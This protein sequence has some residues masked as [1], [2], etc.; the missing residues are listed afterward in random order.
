M[1]IQKFAIAGVFLIGT[2]LVAPPATRAQNC[3]ASQDAAVDCFVG[4]SVKT[5]LTSLRYGMNM[6]QFKAYGVAVSRILQAQQ[7]YLAL[8][9]MASAVAD[10]MPPTNV[11]GTAN[12]AAQQTAMNAIVHAEILCGLT[13]LPAE[14]NE[15]QAK[16]FSLDMIA[17]MNDTHGIMLSPGFLLRAI[18]SYVVTATVNGVV[19]WTQVNSQ[20]ATMVSGLSSAGLL[21]LPSSV[22]LANGQLFA[23]DLAQAIYNYKQATRKATL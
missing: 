6:N 17:S 10:A 7:D 1:N 23:Q 4:N 19:N 20:L 2:T 14:V 16:Y 22:T 8:A 11:D 15:Q 13:P 5:G 9:G 3:V 12:S 18:D 21:K